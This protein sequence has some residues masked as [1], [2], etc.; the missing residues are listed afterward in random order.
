M[1]IHTGCRSDNGSREPDVKKT[2]RENGGKAPVGEPRPRPAAYKPPRIAKKRAA[3]SK[4]TLFTGSGPDSG[5]VTGP[6]PEPPAG[7]RKA[8]GRTQMKKLLVVAAI[9]VAGCAAEDAGTEARDPGSAGRDAQDRRGRDLHGRGGSGGAHPP[10]QLRAH[11]RRARARPEPLMEITS[12][13][14]AN[15]VVDGITQVYFNV[16]QRDPDRLARMVTTARSGEPTSPSR[17]RCRTPP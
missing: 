17:T 8:R 11:R 14:V 6:S 12:I 4:A 1:L 5:G 7:P 13:G 16:E 10:D 15:T 9:A 3:V 2:E